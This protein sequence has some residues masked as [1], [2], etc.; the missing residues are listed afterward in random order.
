[1][2]VKAKIHWKAMIWRRNWPTPREALRT[3]REKPMV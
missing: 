1:M 2:M 3:L